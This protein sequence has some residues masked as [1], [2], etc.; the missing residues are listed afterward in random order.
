VLCFL[1]LRGMQ[2][3]IKVLLP[4]FFGFFITHVVLIVGGI[5]MQ[6]SRLPTLIPETVSATSELA[7]EMGWLFAASLFLRA[8]SL[9]SGTYTDA[10]AG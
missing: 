9:G 2:E 6:T 10:F 8:Y 1:N 5:G 4:I 7:K 3:S